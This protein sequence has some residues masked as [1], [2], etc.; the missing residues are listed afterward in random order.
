MKPIDKFKAV[1]FPY[2]GNKLRYYKE[3]IK[4]IFEAEGKEKY[5]DVFAGALAVPLCI[6]RDFPSVHVW[7]NTYDRQLEPLIKGERLEGDL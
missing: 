2:M 6:K 1:S 3:W 5:I 7:A 4:P